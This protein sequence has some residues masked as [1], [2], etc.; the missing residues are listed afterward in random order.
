MS[1]KYELELCCRDPIKFSVCPGKG[2]LLLFDILVVKT[3]ETKIRTTNGKTIAFGDDEI[4]S[5]PVRAHVRIYSYTLAIHS[6]C[7]RYIRNELANFNID[8]FTCEYLAEAIVACAV[9]IINTD[10]RGM[11]IGNTAFKVE[12]RLKVTGEKVKDE[13]HVLGGMK[14]EVFEGGDGEFSCAVCLEEVFDGSECTRTPCSHLFHYGCI[15]PWLVKNKS[16]PICRRV[17]RDDQN[18]LYMS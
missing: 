8:S 18:E 3:S 11:D 4:T 10:A 9:D 13:T 16:C 5:P 15:V 14:K 6:T 2:D 7:K 17:V 12:G 1:H